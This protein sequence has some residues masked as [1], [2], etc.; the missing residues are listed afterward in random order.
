MQYR[1]AL[2]RISHAKSV[3]EAPEDVLR[4]SKD[5]KTTRLAPSTSLRG[6]A[7]PGQRPGLDDLLLEAV[8]LLQYDDACARC[9][10][11]ASSTC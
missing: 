9:G 7:P 5:P 1:A 6:P 11:G 8:R 2:S 4:N 3:K 10:T